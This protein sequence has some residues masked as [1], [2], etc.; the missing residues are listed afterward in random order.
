ME[1]RNSSSM[2][3]IGVIPARWASTRFK[4]KVLAKIN[5]IP[6]I[7]HVWQQAK[8]SR[9][10]DEV[11]IACDDEKVFDAAQGFGA[12]V[13]MTSPAH[14]SGTERIAQA[15]RHTD[16]KIIVNIQ[17]DEP[18]IQPGVIDSLAQALLDDE[19]CSMGTVIKVITDENDLNN[20]NVVKVVIDQN[21]NALYFSRTAIPFHREK[22]SLK[23][24]CY[25]K[26]LGLYAY[27]RDF[28]LAFKDLP[29]SRLEQAEKLEQLRALEAGH[30]IKTVETEHDTIGV[31]TPED[32][33]R[34][35]GLM[36]QGSKND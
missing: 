5:G 31:D 30:K 21:K 7:Q 11:F 26:H 1:T 14:S 3:I 23:D 4:G 36:K 24:S 19:S 13:V 9:L 27:R 28:L 2:N 6:M 15:F 22:E 33:D 32:L 20:P 29:V 8:K 25:Y 18:L 12:A 35:E 17:G 34:V 10:L 16:A